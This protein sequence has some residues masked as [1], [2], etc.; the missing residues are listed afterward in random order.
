MF[1]LKRSAFAL[2]AALALLGGATAA[3]AEWRP[4]EDDALLFDAQL[5]Q[6]KLG[7]GVRG[8]RTPEGI[9]L[10]F[11]D[12]VAAL[13][14]PVIVDKSGVTAS[15]WIFEE[16][17]ILKI[18]RKSQKV[19]VANKQSSLGGSIRDTPEGWCVSADSLSAW[20]G[21]Q[22]TADQRNAILRISSKTKL[23]VQLAAERRARASRVR[24]SQQVD[25]AKLPQAKL[26]Y[27][28]WRMPSLDAV[29]TVAGVKDKVRGNR[30]DG[31]YDLYVAG[32]V[33]RVSVDARIA[34]ERSALPTDL[35]L[36]AYRS[37]PRGKLLGPLKATHFAMGDVFSYASPLVANTVPGRGGMVTNRP[38]SR[39]DTYD[40]KTFRGEMPT[41]W[42]AELYR[43]G[44]LIAVSDR[45][46]DGRYEFADVPL[47]FGHNV[48]EVVL[49]GP[50]G[51]V[52]RNRETIAVGPESIPPKQTW[53]WAS[54]SQDWR[55]LVTLQRD[56]SPRNGGWRGTLGVE[57]GVNQKTSLAAQVHSLMIDD[58]RLTYVEG[59]VRRSIGSALVEIGGAYQSKGGIA[60]RAQVLA[61][62]G[63]TYLAAESI[64]ARDFRSDRITRDLVSSQSLSLERT[65]NIGKLQVPAR[66]EGRYTR[67]EDGRGSLEG[68]ARA[69]TNLG[70][71]SIT[72]AVDWQKR[73]DRF[74]SD[75]PA[76]NAALLANGSIGTTRVRGEIRWQLS[77][78]S[79]FSSAALVAE[80]RI[81]DKSSL[82]G[83]LGY[84]RDLHRVRAGVGYVRTFDKFALSVNGEVASDGSV[85]AGLNLAFSLGPNPRGG[86]RVASQKLAANG[87]VFARVFRDED[88]DGV[89]DAGEPYEK[90]VQ[91]MV[92]RR[93]I[94]N[95]TDAR[96]EAAIDGLEP[97]V[98]VL[99]GIDPS[100]LPDPLIQPASPG[101]VVTPRRG[102]PT[103]VELPLVGAGEIVG[104]LLARHGDA[105][106][107]VDIELV[108]GQGLVV[109]T[110]R[111]D[112][113][114]F[115]L[116][117]SV[118]Y[119]KYQ[120][121]INKLS[122][123]AAGLNQ[124][125]DVGAT[126]DRD[127]PSVRLGNVEAGTSGGK[128]LAYRSVLMEG[129]RA[130]FVAAR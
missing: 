27:R 99:V 66:L 125:L 109:A 124:A 16:H 51:Q 10:N 71:I 61:Q 127:H 5:G 36:Q 128:R 100:S 68:L 96:G 126:L 79:H 34:A 43:N 38:L 67:W 98:P 78:E 25:L 55:D 58:E 23:P 87:S 69:S 130:E 73:W 39:P 104:N 26:P 76:V 92:A 106:Q 74:G 7:D 42:D 112:F 14:V 94:E 3:R 35:K 47:L 44:Q 122:A 52:R 60:A 56:K 24:P 110:T 95:M 105:R 111:T 12:V 59:T 17:N 80:R 113:D 46:T 64:F 93:P 118:P 101:V 48:V 121:R 32:E 63:N 13:D 114:G 54:I 15:G 84:E 53:Y 40:R 37:D 83:D 62:F 65:F 41:G 91:L 9:C 29:V 22:F 33:A 89:R 18:N 49:Y 103:I 86:M 102:V 107:G 11:A 19:Q 88:D 123:A 57:R 28:M 45:R 129:P 6:L 81:S 117:E 4:N 70:R 75:P 50:Q 85:A 1:G 21:I 77:P 108:N 120:L 20:F 8:Y 115:F 72:G 30:V 31:R 90:D 2:A 97:H 119:G 82:R 116:F